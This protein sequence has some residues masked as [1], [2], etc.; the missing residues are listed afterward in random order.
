MSY[1]ITQ[2]SLQRI[3]EWLLWCDQAA[4]CEQWLADKENLLK[5][6]DLGDAPDAVQVLIKS[7]DAFEET[8]KK[9]GEKVDHLIGEANKLINSDNE[10]RGDIEARR[11]EILC[12]HKALLE[13]SGHRRVV[14]SDS[15]KY[16]EF[17]RSCGELITWINAKL[18]LAYDES[19]L[20]PTN[21]RA[22][23]QKHLAFDSELTENEKRLNTVD[24]QGKQLVSERHFMSDQVR[25]QMN[26]LRGGWDE[27]RMKSA[28]KT[29][30]LREA[31]DAHTLQRKV[32]DMER[33]LDRV[34]CSLF[35][36]FLILDLGFLYYLIFSLKLSYFYSRENLRDAHCLYEWT[37]GAEE[38]LEWISDKM[39]LARSQ[40]CGDSLQAA[41]SLQKTHIALEKELDS[42][43]ATIHEIESKGHTMIR[44]KHFAAN[45]IE[46]TI[47]KLSSALLSIKDAVSIRQT[48]L[49]QAIDS[50]QYY[51]EVAEA[52]QW[53]K[54]QMPV[55]TNQET[56]RDQSAAEGY[57]RRLTILD[58]EVAQFLNEVDRL[59]KR[60]E[61]LQDH[62]DS[63]QIVA[64]QLKLEGAYSDLVRECNRRR[65][66]LVDAGRY[67]RYVRQVDDL[68]DWLHDK[69]KIASSEEYGRDLEDCVHLID[70]FETV[71]RELAAAGERVA[72]V[73][74]IQE[75][76]LRSGHPYAASIRAKGA[77][78]QRLWTTVNEVATERQQAL[79]GARQV[80]RFDQEADQTLN[81]LQDKEAT[82]V[83]MEREDLSH[84]DLIAI[85]TQMQRHDEFVHGLK[86]V[87]KQVAE[88][89]REAER[90]WTAFPNTREHLEVRKMDMEEQLKDIVEGA[91]KHHEY[92]H[93]DSVIYLRKYI[94]IY[95]F[96]VEND[97][98]LV[99]SVDAAE[100]QLRDFNDFLVTLDAQSERCEN[101]KALTLIEQNFSR[102][103]KKEVERTRIAE[104]EQKRRDTIKIVEKGNILA[105]R[106]QERERR[107]TQEIS[108][109]RTSPNDDFV[110]QTLPR[111]A[112]RKERS[113]TT[114][115]VG[116]TVDA[117]LTGGALTVLSPSPSILTSGMDVDVRKTPSFN[118]RRTPSH[119]VSRSSKLEDLGAIDMRGFVDRKQDLQSGGKRATIRSW[120][121]YYNILCGQLLCFF[122]DESA[123]YENVAAAPPVYIYG[124]RC[125]AYPEYVKRKHAYRLSTQDGAEFIFACGD[126]GQMLEWVAK[127]K[128]H[129]SLAPSNQL[130]SYSYNVTPSRST[131]ELPPISARC[132]PS[133]I[134]NSK[135][136]LGNNGTNL[137]T[138]FES[139][140]AFN[141][142]PCGLSE[143]SVMRAYSTIPRGE[144]FHPALS[145]PSISTATSAGSLSSSS[146]YFPPLFGIRK[147]SINRQPSKRQSIYAESIYGELEES[148]E[149]KGGSQFGAQHDDYVLTSMDSITMYSH[150]VVCYLF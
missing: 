101:I 57:L 110:S 115:I 2:A 22:K 35:I 7:H 37:T 13:S 77:D 84:A 116:V 138:G 59:K 44:Q 31:Y 55:A 141:S 8:V 53:I 111:K 36:Y 122:K 125:E 17:I 108:L 90:L 21:L 15:K 40:D 14:L 42:R 124:A 47:D 58:K 133:D 69:Y 33:W 126:E 64:R 16:H 50:H 98:R 148:K 68:S 107:K 9:Q 92:T 56:G 24:S 112:E 97:W 95:K 106:R 123:F 120:K 150:N 103:R 143:P 65:T 67:H 54:N 34:I 25:A 142:L 146:N 48:R 52:E 79:A 11:D 149:V 89:C 26:E 128:F 10:Y 100:N 23:L 144:R 41:M 70:R 139:S 60:V 85:T 43:Q 134:L 51:T 1:I 29:Q 137:E 5:Q 96:F 86:A 20:D 76:L 136:N 83:A 113:K 39:P 32:E 72:V 117:S 66:Q 12:R 75:E 45:E 87:E 130:K 99:D 3:L 114:A 61:S 30:R 104:E 78:L 88:L 93:N 19:Y 6:G 63:N 49:Q 73:H 80:H 119:S 127:I 131:E 62:L 105:N 102:L 118:T 135:I 28:L 38:E 132:A 18:Q 74:R 109:F 94:Y 145:P 129:A 91:H 27:L 82:G 4:M 147:S 81:W 46:N 121:N 140:R 71:V